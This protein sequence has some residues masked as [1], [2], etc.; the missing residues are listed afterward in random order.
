MDGKDNLSLSL[1]PFLPTCSSGSL[2][3]KLQGALLIEPPMVKV[4]HCRLQRTLRFEVSEHSVSN[5][6]FTNIVSISFFPACLGNPIL[7]SGYLR[8]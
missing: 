5:Y 4:S 7:T 2:V 3:R 6:L 8:A 1:F